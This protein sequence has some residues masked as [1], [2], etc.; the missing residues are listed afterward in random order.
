[1]YVF[2][3]ELGISSCKGVRT[4]VKNGNRAGCW[5][6]EVGRRIGGIYTNINILEQ[7]DIDS[8]IGG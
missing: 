2:S 7:T 1:M 8:S 6:L 5:V 4:A 3:T